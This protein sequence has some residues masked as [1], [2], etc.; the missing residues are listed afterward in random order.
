MGRSERRRSRN[1]RREKRWALGGGKPGQRV[2]LV[3]RE[4]PLE[5]VDAVGTSC[6]SAIR[7]MWHGTSAFLV[8]GGPSLKHVDISR[9]RDRG[10]LSLGINNVA[11]HIP[12]T[13]FT[14][15]DPAMKFSEAIW[16]DGRII[17]FIPK[18]MLAS[19][20]R[21]K[22]DGQFAWSEYATGDCPAVFGIDR[23]A[24][25]DPATFFSTP[26]A[27]WGAKGGDVDEWPNIRFTMFVGFRL[28][29][30]LGVRRV[31]WLGVDFF[32]D[33]DLKYSFEQDKAGAVRGGGSSHWRKARIMLE[34]IKPYLQNAG[35]E[36]YDAGPVSQLGVWDRCSFEDAVS[37]CQER[38]GPLPPDLTGWY[39]KKPLE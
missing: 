33:G 32:K 15:G 39:S 34:A 25:F 5:V 4:D 27:S 7:N 17:K 36:C 31:F 19:R 22:R 37:D 8:G 28:L 38:L 23:G 1:E 2:E 12:C 9:L 16:H 24:R 21:C 35:M 6:G 20:I 29:H 10:V 18:S 11:A 3:R 26:Y 13:A 30:F 14:C